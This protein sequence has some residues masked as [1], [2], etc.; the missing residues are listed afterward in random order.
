LSEPW[1]ILGIDPSTVATGRALLVA[2]NGQETVES[3]GVFAPRGEDLN[4][5]LLNAYDWMQQLIEVT[6]PN[7]LAIETPFF[8]LNAQTLITLA[9]LGAAYRLAAMRAGLRVVGIPPAMRCTAIG[10]AG[11]AA[12]D[13]VRHTVNAIYGLD[14]TDHNISDAVAVAAAAA[15]KLREESYRV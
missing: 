9:S 1:R 6:T 3:M 2:E 13:R 4:N 10:L 8:R 12:K 15:I 11:D 7:V 5:K 14:L